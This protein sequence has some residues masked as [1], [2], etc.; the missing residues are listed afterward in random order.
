MTATI[1]RLVL[2]MLLLPATGGVFVLLFAAMIRPSGPP[3]SVALLLL[4]AIVYA[5]VAAYW[6]LLWRRTVRWTRARL[7]R[8]GLASAVCLVGG[9]LFGAVCLT[10]NRTLPDPI[11][12]LAGGGFVPIVWVLATVLLWRE[13]PAERL[14]RLAASSAASV[15][16]PLC[17]YDLRGLSAARCPE[18]GTVFTLEELAA[19]QPQ[20][21]ESPM[22]T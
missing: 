21:Q 16:C 6:I 20:R 5:F 2:A 13:T 12:I 15:L 7:W 4:W 10:L 1:A 9:V 3:S 18:C 19:A 17:G 11:A 22:E 14:A 8:T